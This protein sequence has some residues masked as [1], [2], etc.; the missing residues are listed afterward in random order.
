MYGSPG[1]GKSFL[2]DM[3]YGCIPEHI[4]KRRVHFNSFMLDVHKRVHQWRLRNKGGR[5]RNFFTVTLSSVVLI[6]LVVGDPLKYL[7]LELSRDILLCFDEF[8]VTDVA[9]AMLL[10]RLFSELWNNG[11]MIVATSNRSPDDLYLN[12]LQRELF[13]PFIELL[14]RVSCLRSVLQNL[15]ITNLFWIFA[16]ESSD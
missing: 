1:C 8:Q 13:I 4:P 2:M 16:D 9:D 10:R 7:A 14:K 6:I 15:I 5:A 12:G 3:F 11:V